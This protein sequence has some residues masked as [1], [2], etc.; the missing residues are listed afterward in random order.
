MPYF[1]LHFFFIS[2]GER[3]S[4]Y[5]CIICVSYFIDLS[6]LIIYINS[7]GNNMSFAYSLQVFFPLFTVTFM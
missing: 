1:D 6:I 4:M 5:L 3:L 7:L 2:E